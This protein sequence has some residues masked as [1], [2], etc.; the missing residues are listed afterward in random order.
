MRAGWPGR[1]LE[2]LLYQYRT[3]TG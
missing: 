1:D 3:R 2:F